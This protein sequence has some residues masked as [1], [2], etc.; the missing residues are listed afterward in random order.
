VLRALDKAVNSGSDSANYI[1]FSFA[2]QTFC[3]MFIHYVDLHVP[4]W[5]NYKSVFYNY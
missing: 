1:F 5:D 2:N 3:G 4:F